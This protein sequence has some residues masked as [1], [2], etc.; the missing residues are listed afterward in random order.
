MWTPCMSR[1]PQHALT[2]ALGSIDAPQYGGLSSWVPEVQYFN[3]N[4]KV[5]CML[6]LCWCCT[7]QIEGKK[8][9]SSTKE[10]YKS[11][12]C[13]TLAY[14]IHLSFWIYLQSD[15]WHGT[16]WHALVKTIPHPLRILF[17]WC[18]RWVSSTPTPQNAPGKNCWFEY[19]P[20]TV[21]GLIVHV[22]INKLPNNSGFKS[23]RL[24]VDTTLLCTG[25]MKD[26][27]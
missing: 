11:L 19:W 18:R 23:A 17:S 12:L 7:L 6:I 22:K 20:D 5:Q 2:F 3:C 14:Y 13:A 24:L 27:D 26:L 9:I 4:S 25:R 15:K 1:I 21:E 10:G 16:C 8:Y